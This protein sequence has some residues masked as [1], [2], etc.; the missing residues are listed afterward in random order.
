MKFGSCNSLPI[1][2]R[3]GGDPGRS[4]G[5]LRRAVE[6]AHRPELRGRCVWLHHGFRS[7]RINR[8]QACGAFTAPD[9]ELP[10]V[11]K[12][13]TSTNST[14][15]LNVT[16]PA[17]LVTIKGKSLRDGQRPTLDRHCARRPMTMNP[18][19]KA[20][21]KWAPRLSKETER[22]KDHVDKV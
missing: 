16:L 1:T 8:I 22:L 17:V 18:E 21:T 10:S 4:H 3:G 15:R 2:I 9:G 13:K 5:L 12:L 7:A 11:C 20:G 6:W 19:A 14:C